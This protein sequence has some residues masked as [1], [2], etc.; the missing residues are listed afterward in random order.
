MQKQTKNKS[1]KNQKPTKNK[2]KTKQKQTKNTPKTSQKHTKSKP[3]TNQKQTKNKPKTN[4]KH[5]KNKPKTNQKQTKNKPK[6]NCCF[7]G[8]FFR[9]CF[10]RSFFSGC[11]VWTFLLYFSQFFFATA[12]SA[13]LLLLMRL[14][15]LLRRLLLPPTC[16]RLRVPV[17]VH[18][19]VPLQMCMCTGVFTLR[20]LW[21]FQSCVGTASTRWRC[22]RKHTAA[23]LHWVRSYMIRL[24]CRRRKGSGWVAGWMIR[25][26]P[27]DFQTDPVGWLVGWSGPI[28]L[29][30]KRIRLDGCLDDPA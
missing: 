1:V 30:F 14:L 25:P 17:C 24:P 6:T 5:I 22:Q 28:L 12:A 27:F 11:V 2:A 16:V 9:G 7:V 4:Q 3:K 29:T 13:L 20:V 10:L 26:N 21:F 8:R 23:E 18:R 15:L 19:R